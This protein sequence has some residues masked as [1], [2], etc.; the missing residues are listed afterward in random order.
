MEY[1][2]E[3]LIG[4]CG[5]YCDSCP[6]YLQDKCSGC[7]KGQQAGDCFTKDCVEKK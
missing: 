4:K 5:F 7:T 2:K 1:V 3:S 6:T